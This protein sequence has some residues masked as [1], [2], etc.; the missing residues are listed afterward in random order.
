M[1]RGRLRLRSLGGKEPL[2]QEGPSG[3]LLSLDMAF[4]HALARLEVPGDVST[5]ATKIWTACHSAVYDSTHNMQ[6]STSAGCRQG[7]PLYR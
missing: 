4:E 3:G 1:P 5:Y 7:C 2:L 6:A